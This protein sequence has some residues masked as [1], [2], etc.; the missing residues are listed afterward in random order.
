M[1]SCQQQQEK[2]AATKIKAAATAEVSPRAPKVSKSSLEPETGYL[3][4]RLEPSLEHLPFAVPEK[5][6]TPIC[7]LHRFTARQIG[8][9]AN[10]PYGAR[11]SVMR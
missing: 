4:N 11:A 8:K 7:H 3:K 2:L 1:Y 5:N 9:G 10:I 6:T